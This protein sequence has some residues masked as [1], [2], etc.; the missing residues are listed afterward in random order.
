MSRGLCRTH[1][2]QFNKA[3]KKTLAKGVKLA[4]FEAA[5]IAKKLLLP[6]A[7]LAVD[8]YEGTLNELYEEK[9]SR[10]ENSQGV[11]PKNK[12]PG[13]GRKKSD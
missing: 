3:K 13:A 5:L 1:Y 2:N 12:K 10:A 8:P 4:D 11:P 9:K 6:N 7:K